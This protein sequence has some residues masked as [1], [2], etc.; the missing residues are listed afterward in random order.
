MKAKIEFPTEKWGGGAYTA[1]CS[2]VT[3]LQAERIKKKCNSCIL[4]I[5][6]QIE[7]IQFFFAFI[8]VLNC[9]YSFAFV[10]ISVARVASFCCNEIH[11]TQQWQQCI[12]MF[13]KIIRYKLVMNARVCSAVW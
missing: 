4:G 2:T 3:Q 10:A 11:R 8:S 1:Q 5:H 7:L 12:K 6:D 13:L 9:I